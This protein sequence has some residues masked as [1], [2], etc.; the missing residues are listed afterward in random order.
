MPENS[1]SAAAKSRDPLSADRWRDAK[2]ILE[3]ALTLDSSEW[4]SFLDLRC[5]A[6]QHLRNEVE[7]LL[8][9]HEASS[10]FLEQPL[11]SLD[12][13][14]QIE[15]PEGGES[16]LI[17]SR[18]G[19]YRLEREL[20]HGGMGAVYLATRADEEF[21]KSVAIKLIRVEKQ[22]DFTVRRFRQERQILARLEHAYVARLI[23][24]GATGSGMPYLVMEYVEGEVL[25]QYC[26]GRELSARERLEL[27]LKICSAVQYA[28]ERS[29]I[30]RDLKPA[31][32]L[33][34]PNGCPKLLDFGIAKM[35]EPENPAANKEPTVAG[36]RMLT[37]AYAS[38]EQMRGEPA[39]ARSDVYSLG[40]ILYEL[41]CGERPSL[42]T[43][44]HSSAGSGEKEQHLSPNLR[45]II[46]NAIRLDPGERYLSVASFAEDIDRYLKG[47][48]TNATAHTDP[49]SG[50]GRIS[51]GVLPFRELGQDTNAD[52]FLRS[53]ITDA[54]ITRLSKVARLSVRP[55]SAVLRYAQTMDAVHAARELR[56]EYLLEGT[57]HTANDQVRLNV[58]LVSSETGLAVWAAQFEEQSGDLLRL[59]DSISEQIA[60]ALIPQLTG[61][62]RLSLS[63]AGTASGKAHEAYLRG[64]Y[65]WSRSAGDPEELAKS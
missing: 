41:L 6:D 21:R 58:Q 44:Q 33:V 54:L 48:P 24:G 25:T 28:H 46:F 65:H 57:L 51:I 35:L 3:L 16:P 42:K 61:E 13:F 63:R 22:S 47:L 38:P 4:S 56:V 23:D 55:T 5:G 10:D 64:R 27:F 43:V 11:A 49:G 29:I 19:A 7:S 30:H 52:P 8:V 34:E 1:Q 32:I 36:L 40:V 37:P 20:G 15:G 9:A 53:A 60:F 14:T 12:G 17:G 2:A 26:E 31:N 18:I 39:T 50:P 59:E 62:E 45:A